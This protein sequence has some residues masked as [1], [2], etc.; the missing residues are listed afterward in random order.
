MPE[1]DRTEVVA[2]ARR[3]L[4]R[5]CDGLECRICGAAEGENH[6]PTDPC[7]IVADLVFAVTGEEVYRRTH[8]AS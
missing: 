7:G 4:E 6:E 5:Q 2:R 3:W 8:H 1:K